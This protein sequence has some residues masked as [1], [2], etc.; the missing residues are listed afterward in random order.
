[1]RRQDIHSLIQQI[2]I[3]CLPHARYWRYSRDQMQNSC[4]HESFIVMRGKRF[5]KN[6]TGEVPVVAQQKRI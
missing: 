3:E 6:L 2:F 4:L 5:L 1:M